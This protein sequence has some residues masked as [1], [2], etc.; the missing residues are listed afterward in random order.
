M[1]NALAKRNP[2]LSL[3]LCLLLLLATFP[4]FSG[5]EV[6]LIEFVSGDVEMIRNGAKAPLNKGNGLYAGDEILTGD[7]ST[8]VITYGESKI[9]LDPNS[10]L[11]IEQLDVVDEKTK[12]FTTKLFLKLGNMMIKFFNRDKKKDLKVRTTDIN[13]GVKGT[14]FFLG[15]DKDKTYSDVFM[16][17]EEGVVEVQ[18]FATDDMDVV[19]AG[20]GM[21]IKEGFEITKP[22]AYKFIKRMNWN[23][24]GGAGRKVKSNF[25]SPEIKF[26]R[27]GEFRQ[28]K[29]ILKARFP[30]TFIKQLPKAEQNRYGK[31]L[32]I[33]TLKNAARYK[34]IKKKKQQLLEQGA[35]S[36][37][38][39]KLK[40]KHNR[41]KKKLKER[42]KK[43]KEK[44]RERRKKKRKKRKRRALA[45]EG[46]DD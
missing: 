10:Y 41:K 19:K 36:P 17:V 30:R 35:S 15:Y 4:L 27:R 18:S 44:D 5:E 6:A 25:N 45:P 20:Q 1:S 12:K 40:K 37:Q 26:K 7:D 42:R 31:I 21:F 34:K 9:K 11:I 39:N 23:M 38:L 16:A 13:L 2:L 22:I 24:N 3:S 33:N 29:A 28:N 32:K 46:M 43:A 14:H 8:V